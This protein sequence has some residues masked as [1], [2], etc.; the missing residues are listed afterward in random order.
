MIGTLMW[1]APSSANS[2]L[3]LQYVVCAVNE[4]R[5]WEFSVTCQLPRGV[6]FHIILE[7]CMLVKQTILHA[8]AVPYVSRANVDREVIC[9]LDPPLPFNDIVSHQGN[10]LEGYTNLRHLPEISVQLLHIIVASST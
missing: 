8:C 2:E 10:P 1:T 7:Q 6:V 5:K 9:I 3:G 4:K